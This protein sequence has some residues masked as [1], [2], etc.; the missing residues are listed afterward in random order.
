MSELP[1]APQELAKELQDPEEADFDSE[2]SY[3]S[4]VSERSPGYL[5]DLTA[6]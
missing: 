2:D 5:H 4:E 1:L 6:T 3:D